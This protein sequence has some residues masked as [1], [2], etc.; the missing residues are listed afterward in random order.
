MILIR[1]ILFPLAIIYWL[2]TFIR[3]WLYDKGYLKSTAFNVPV[4]AVGNLSAGGT[5]KTPQ[6]EYLINMLADSYKVAVLSRGY[7]RKSNGFVLADD[8]ATVESIGDEPFQFFSKFKNKCIVAVDA[9]RR[10]G[11]TKLMALK[12]K[13]QVILL[14]DA[15][16]HRKVKASMY[17][18]LTAYD[19]LFVDDF[20]LPFGNLR[21]SAIGKKR[22]NVVIVTKCP[23]DLN[24]TEKE[25]IISKLNVNVPVYFSEI[26]YSDYLINKNGE[27]LRLS[28]AIEDIGVVV[29]GI[30]NPKLFLEK[31]N[32]KNTKVMIYPDHHHF[33]T[34]EI[35]QINNNSNG[36]IIL[37]TEKDFVRI[38][39]K[40]DDKL[41]FLQIHT[42]IDNLQFKKEVLD[43]L[44]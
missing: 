22:A 30:A 6:I 20:I 12:D 8:N 10:N 27:K 5:G 17:I 14:D 28:N 42:T 19:E 44:K 2:V 16:Q 41:F 24:Q 4:I 18:L 25:C 1:K 9:D 32:A 29:S 13:P 21:E 11:I 40:F 23:S 35:H 43:F 38:K 33:T 31:I 39:N 37:T 36:K 7:K 34:K 15:F 3:N 26:V